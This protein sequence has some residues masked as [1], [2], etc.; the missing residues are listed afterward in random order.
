MGD[1]YLDHPGYKYTRVRVDVRRWVRESGLFQSGINCTYKCRG[2][3]LPAV[4]SGLACNS[5]DNSLHSVHDGLLCMMTMG[6]VDD[7]DGTGRLGLGL[8]STLCFKII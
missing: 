1:Y 8:I 2:S 4:A 5:F 7:D 6:R 3:R